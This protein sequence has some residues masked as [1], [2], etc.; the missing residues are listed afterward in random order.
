M[1]REH[2]GTTKGFVQLSRA[3]YG[4]SSLENSE[5]TDEVSFGLYCPEGGTSGEMVVSWVPLGGK[6]IPSLK[7][8]S[9]GWSALSNFHDLIDLLGTHDS[10]DPSPE[11]FCE[12][13][14]A[15]GFIDRTET[16]NP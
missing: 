14:L 3:Y 2:E 5:K 1:E 4:N 9:D 6:I 16:V 10:E 13:L 8:F 12:Y 15:C 11:E 7:I